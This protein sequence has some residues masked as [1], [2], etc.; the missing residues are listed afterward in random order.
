MRYNIEMTKIFTLTDIKEYQK[1]KISQYI[2][3][4]IKIVKEGKRKIICLT[5]TKPALEEILWRIKM[6]L[7]LNKIPYSE[8][9]EG[10]DFSME[11]EKKIYLYYTSELDKKY[12]NWIT[13]NH[14]GVA[15]IIEDGRQFS[16][17]CERIEA[18]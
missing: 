17:E 1:E 14:P 2:V 9:N 5:G 12:D 6:R 11:P 16:G 4:S 15:L 10:I 7:G 8:S 3:E 18:N 13:K